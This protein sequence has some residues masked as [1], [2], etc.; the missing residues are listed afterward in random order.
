MGRREPPNTPSPR[1]LLTADNAPYVMC[2]RLGPS[3]CV[4]RRPNLATMHTWDFF[5]EAKATIAGWAGTEETTTTT[6]DTNRLDALLR[7]PESDHGD[8]EVAIALT[9]L[10][11][12]EFQRYGTSG[13]QTISNEDAGLLLRALR[14][15]LR[16]L[17]VPFDPPFRDFESFRS[18][19]M[20]KDGYGIWQA[21]RDILQDV[22]DPLH[23]LLEDREDEALGSTLAQPISPRGSLGWTGVDEEIRE[24]R[25]HFEA[26]RTEQDY[27]NVGNDAVAVLEA[28]SRTVYDHEKHGLEGTPEPAIG[29]TKERLTRYIEVSLNGSENAALRKLTRAAIEAA[30]ETKHRRTGDRRS[31]G[32]AADTVILLANVLRRIDAT[33]V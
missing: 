16:R 23:R 22:L 1:A 2:G 33:Q 17:D 14:S 27:S 6:L 21:R 7:R 32:I 15:V 3:S 19:W 9:R 18:Y 4:Y 29:Q 30:Q 25:R 28:L 12:D 24:L 11:H 10:A 20:R 5:I 31:A 8:L 26:A 13:D